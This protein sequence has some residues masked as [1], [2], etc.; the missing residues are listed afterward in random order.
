M[1]YNSQSLWTDD[2]SACLL[3]ASSSGDSVLQPVLTVI[4]CMIS[5]SLHQVQYLLFTT[6]A[7]KIHVCTGWL[8]IKYPTGEYA[9]CLQPMV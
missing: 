3:L 8:K 2:N 9:V 7:F 4:D 6:A 1:L 5:V